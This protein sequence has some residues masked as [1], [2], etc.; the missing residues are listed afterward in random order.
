MLSRHA[1]RSTTAVPPA[2]ASGL[3]PPRSKKIC[4]QPRSQRFRSAAM[5]H[6]Q[7]C[8]TPS[9]CP[10]RTPA[11]ETN[12]DMHNP[13]SEIATVP[14]GIVEVTGP[15]VLRLMIADPEVTTELR[16]REAGEER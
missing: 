14:E 9:T 15:M 5:T 11:K 6:A 7:P 13:N 12:M 10:T 2:N 3:V 16:R 4:A 1:N 8:L